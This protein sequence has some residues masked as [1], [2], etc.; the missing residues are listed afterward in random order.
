[1]E[2]SPTASPWLQVC[3]GWPLEVPLKGTRVFPFTQ[4][5]FIQFSPLRELWGEG[6]S[7]TRFRVEVNVA[8]TP[9]WHQGVGNEGSDA[10]G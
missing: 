9:S 7:C 10:E 8:R 6:V 1:M 2:P 5:T 3:R 4:R